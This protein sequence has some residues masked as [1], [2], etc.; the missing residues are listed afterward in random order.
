MADSVGGPDTTAVRARV[1]AIWK[2]VLALSWPIMAEQTTR[3]LMRTVDIIVTG[4][5]SPAAIAAIGLADLYARLPLRIGLGLGGGAIA[6]SSQDTGADATAT[7]DEAIT[8]ALCLGAL[9]GI[10]FVFFGYFL[11]R[12]SIAFLGANAEVAQMGGTYLAIIMATA[13]ARH[14]GLIAARSLQGTGDTRTPMYVNVAANVLNAGGSVILGLGLF[15]AP[16]LEIVGVGI[17]TAVANVYTAVALVAIIASPY[18]QGSLVRPRQLVIAKQLLVV[19]APRVT[20]GLLA[21]VID[22]PFNSLLLLLGTEVNAA[23]QVGRRLYQQITGPLSRGYNVAASIVVGQRLGEGD[24]DEARFSG[25]AITGLGLATVGV[26]GLVLALFA[27]QFVEIFTDDPETVAHAAAFAQAYGVGAPFL[28]SYIII[29]GALQGAGDTVTPLIARISALAIF[30]LGLSY[31]LAIPLG[32]GVFGIC[33]GIVAHYVWSLLVV[34]A[35][36]Q[37]GGW[38]E[39]AERMMQERGSVPDADVDPDSSD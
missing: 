12:E 20:E 24:P 30:Y 10:P 18:R 33:I 26:I 4:L 22:F 5:F 27:Y 3:T 13:P 17:A 16:Q 25:W 32:Y 23:Y 1:L 35:G 31:V 9:A 37:Y 14:V 34:V 29:A 39:K 28:V 7:R 21:T 6:L 38:A 2:R 19:S 15:G 8:Q 11:G 36:Y